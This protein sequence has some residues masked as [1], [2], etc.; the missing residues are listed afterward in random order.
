LL[1]F[2]FLLLFFLAPADQLVEHFR[3]I[4]V[5]VFVYTS[6]QS[7]HQLLLDLLLDV[8]GDQS[9]GLSDAISFFCLFLDGNDFLF[10]LQFK[11]TC[12][13]DHLSQFGQSLLALMD[14]EG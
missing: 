4:V 2:T 1:F 3:V 10:S 13:N 12:L 5:D 7:L 14:D 11:L 8:G 6:F 9:F